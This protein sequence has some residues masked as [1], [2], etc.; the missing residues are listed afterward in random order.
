MRIS[1]ATRAIP[2]DEKI[3]KEMG[4]LGDGVNIILSVSPYLLEQRQ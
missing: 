1:T 4:G 3:D 2:V